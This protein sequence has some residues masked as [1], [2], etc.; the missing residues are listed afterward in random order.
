MVVN[1]SAGNGK[2]NHLMPFDLYSSSVDIGD[3]GGVEGEKIEISNLHHD[4][5]GIQG[6][7]P[8]QSPFT[9][10]HVGGRQHRHVIMGTGSDNARNRPEG[11]R[12]NFNTTST[13]HG[14]S[15]ADVIGAYDKLNPQ[16]P[17]APFMRDEYA[18]RPINVRNIKTGEPE[19]AQSLGNSA[20]Q[21]TKVD[22]QLR[23]G[24]YERST[25]YFRPLEE[26]RTTP[27][28]RIEPQCLMISSRR[29]PTMRSFTICH[30]QI[31]FLARS[32]LKDYRGL[33]R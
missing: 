19:H 17:P 26:Q 5:Y 16:S 22:A 32:T 12:I 30:L 4:G 29:G 33:V 1:S 7:V 28:S 11:F 13:E 25:E 6:D 18:K 15:H 20:A 23:I 24:N 14:I 27:Y 9:E 3:F 10:T 8:M 2:S 31:L 21:L